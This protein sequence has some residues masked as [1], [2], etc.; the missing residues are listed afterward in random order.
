MSEMSVGNKRHVPFVPYATMFK[1]D[2]SSPC[3]PAFEGARQLV[4]VS[5]GNELSWDIY[6][7]S[8]R[9]FDGRCPGCGIR[10]VDFY[11]DRHHRKLEDG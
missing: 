2:T 1:L 10:A 7:I 5:C 8:T 4:C 11:K 6:S 9:M 3:A